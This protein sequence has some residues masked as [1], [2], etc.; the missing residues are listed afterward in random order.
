M[1]FDCLV[2]IYCTSLFDNNNNN[3]SVFLCQNDWR[4]SENLPTGHSKTNNHDQPKKSNAADDA[5][6]AEVM[7]MLVVDVGVGR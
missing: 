1:L 7:M 5:A 6:A 4:K 3:N 2:D